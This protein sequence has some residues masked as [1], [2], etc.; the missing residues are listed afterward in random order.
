M[1]RSVTSEE[2]EAHST[3]FNKF[4][5]DINKSTIYSEIDTAFKILSII[6]I[7]WNIDK[8]LSSYMA[9]KTDFKTKKRTRSQKTDRVGAPF[10]ANCSF[11]SAS[12]NELC[13]RLLDNEKFSFDAKSTNPQ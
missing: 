13:R 10:S 2:V 6:G 8:I 12:E 5:L 4:A 11:V 7:L 9:E 1:V 3:N